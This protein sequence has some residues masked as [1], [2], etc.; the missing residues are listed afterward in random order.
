MKGSIRSGMKQ[1]MN[2]RAAFGILSMAVL[3]FLSSSD[4]LLQAFPV[5]SFMPNNYHTDFILNALR[6]DVIA[7]FIPILAVL[8]FTTSYI[9]DVKTKIARFFLIRTSYTS[10][11]VSRVVICFLSGG[12][13]V[14]AGIL[15]AWVASALL[16][17]P[18]EKAAEVP[19][20]STAILL[21][22]CGLL[23]MNGGLWAVAGM[24]MSTIMESK[25]IA[26]AS[27]FVIYYLLVILYERYCP[28][29]FLIFPREWFNP[30]NRW[31]FGYLGSAIFMLELTLMFVLLFL[32]RAKRRL[33]E[34]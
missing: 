27:P 5:V 11:L 19:S 4:T 8:P 31:P 33:Q 16:F 28:D 9:D 6:S 12:F 18:V 2:I 25:Y 23:F 30:S 3:I 32:F 22:T 15:L 17:L 14:G 20:E 1:A 7:P 10:Y 26:Y 24:A 21:K 29:Y 34:L 13:V